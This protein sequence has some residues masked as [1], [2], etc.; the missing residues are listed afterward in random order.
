MPDR[1]RTE[2]NQF[3][4]HDVFQTVNTRAIPSPTLITEP[5]SDTF[6]RRFEVLDLR[7]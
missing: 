2:F 1:L 4:G 5:V 6:A 3:A 7:R